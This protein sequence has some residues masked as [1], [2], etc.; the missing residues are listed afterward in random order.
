MYTLER[1]VE[2][3]LPRERVFPFFA[4]ARNLRMRDRVEY[5]LPFGPLGALAHR[6]SV[7]RQLDDIFAFRARVVR[8]LFA[9]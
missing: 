3:P 9:P 7:A 8:E 2:L 5:E 6:L 4:D 1:E